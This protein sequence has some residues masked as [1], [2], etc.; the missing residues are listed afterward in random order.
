VTSLPAKANISFH[1]T[2]VEYQALETE[3]LITDAV[4]VSAQSIDE[5]AVGF[6]LIL[7]LP[8]EID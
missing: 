4:S 8:A 7:I 1:P 6:H 3:I 2:P 5:L